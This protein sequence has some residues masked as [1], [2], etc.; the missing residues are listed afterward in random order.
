MPVALGEL[1]PGDAQLAPPADW[2]DVA[3]GI[4]DLG[5][6]MR[7]HFAHRCQPG[8][9]AIGRECVEAGGRCFGET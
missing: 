2:Y 8:V 3:L 6:R 7:Q 1:V 5:M 4:D 9:D